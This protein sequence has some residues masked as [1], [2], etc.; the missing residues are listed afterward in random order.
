MRTALEIGATATLGRRERASRIHHVF[1]GIPEGLPCLGRRLP[2]I[3][4]GVE[5]ERSDPALE[6]QVGW[7]SPS[8]LHWLTRPR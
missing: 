5:L 1:E 3:A 2:G 4:K 6:A 7:I 8:P